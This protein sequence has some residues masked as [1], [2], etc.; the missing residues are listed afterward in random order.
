MTSFPAHLLALHYLKRGLVVA[1]VP[2]WQDG[3]RAVAT[4][5]VPPGKNPKALAKEGRLGQERA[6]ILLCYA[7]R[8][9]A[10]EVGCL[11]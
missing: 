1:C 2:G 4:F 8:R 10:R 6:A 7:A 3:R 5:S 9:R 11:C